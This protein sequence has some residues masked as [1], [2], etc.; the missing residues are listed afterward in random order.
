M[1]ADKKVKNEPN[2]EAMERVDRKAT[3]R[4]DREESERRTKE[5]VDEKKNSTESPNGINFANWKHEPYCG[6]DTPILKSLGGIFRER[7][8]SMD[9]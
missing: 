3:D 6:L 7:W 5:E 1:E 4:K 8:I 9:I 2:R